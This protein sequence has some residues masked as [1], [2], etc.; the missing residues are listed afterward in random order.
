MTTTETLFDDIA[1]F[2]KESQMLLE[3]GAFV[4]L[5]GLDEQVKILCDAVL[6]LTQEDRIRHAG[7]LQELLGELKALGEALVTQRDRVGDEIQGL[8]QHKK[9]SV[10][11]RIADSRDG[12][13]PKEEDE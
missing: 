9:A 4:E 6:H 7:R 11:Y 13:G 3:Q 10:A 12:F 1:S 2:V 8:S 5:A